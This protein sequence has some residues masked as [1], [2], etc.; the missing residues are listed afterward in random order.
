MKKQ[1]NILQYKFSFKAFTLAEVLITLGIIGVVASITIPI[2]ITNYQKEQTVTQLKKVYTTLSLVVKQSEI[3]NGDSKYWDWGTWLDEPS[4]KQSFN[5]YWAPYLKI[6]KY[7]TNTIP[8]ECGY[9]DSVFYQL[10]KTVHV[11]IVSSSTRTAF[12]L[13]DGILVMIRTP[14]LD[15]DPRT[16]YVDLNAGKGPNIEGKDVFLFVLVAGK[17]L[18]PYG[19]NSNTAVINSNCSIGSNGS[20]C[21]AKIMRDGWQIKDDY[22]WN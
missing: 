15:T 6:L 13:S 7:C 9:S 4:V 3:D 20:A 18:V 1:I 8:T 22:P 11:S 2:L 19:Y 16:I 5:T 12:L 21:A 17:G 10:D 14:V